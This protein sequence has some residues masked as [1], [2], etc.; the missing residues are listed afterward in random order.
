MARRESVPPIIGGYTYVKTLGA[1]GFADVFLYEQA[2]PRRRVAV[3]VLLEGLESDRERRA[4]EAEANLMALLSTHP[5]IVTIYEADIAADGRP[6]IAME[7]CG[8]PSLDA[9]LRQER[10]SVDEALRIGIRVA[11]AVETAHR[12]GIL[13]RDI[14]PAN[15]LVTDYNNPALTDFGIAGTLFGDDID[16]SQ[17][18][19]I[20]WSPPEVF[21]A[22]VP[23]ST[24]I[25][26]YALGATVY[27]LL[28][29]RSP[30]EVP[31]GPN[32][33]ED[34]MSRIQS[35]AATAT[36]RPD[37]PASLEAALARCMVKNPSLRFASAIA[38]ARALQ[39]VQ[40]ELNSVVTMAE[41]LEDSRE[42]ESA[43]GED[44]GDHLRVTELAG[45][46]LTQRR[47]AIPA[48]VDEALMD[49]ERTVL[50]VQEPVRTPA[51]EPRPI[52]QVADSEV[53]SVS[54][55]TVVPD[56]AAPRPRADR[57]QPHLHRRGRRVSLGVWAVLMI[58]VSAGA[59]ATLVAGRGSSAWA[60]SNVTSSPDTGGGSAS[61]ASVPEVVG[62]AG[63]RGST[64]V[65]FTWANPSPEEGDRFLWE[66]V[67]PG[68]EADLT[69]TTDSSVTVPADPDGQTC[70]GVLLARKAGA[71]SNG[72]VVCVP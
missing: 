56:V 26:V 30:F 62:L 27:S 36:G 34:I 63:T 18:M 60:S 59:V 3:K 54:R 22:V 33:R 52:A 47:A 68:A 1:G 44:L 61:S 24:A 21:G 43:G 11:G 25:D 41:V 57:P 5:S 48:P 12:A 32:T 23:A 37:V 53:P 10:I 6:Y 15:I 50:R 49:V 65:V 14:K 42:R 8:R 20:P 51:K 46:D 7:Y 67:T 38:F 55:E 66:V 19:S 28:A 13:H 29:G 17:G 58:A 35:Q 39:D 9:R 72:T 69:I 71:A 40:E 64:G 16:E 45:V 4:F 70:L 31:G 2:M